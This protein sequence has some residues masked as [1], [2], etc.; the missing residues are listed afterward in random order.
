MSRRR[1]IPAQAPLLAA[2]LLLFASPLCGAYRVEEG[3]TFE[4]IAQ[5]EFGSP[6][7]AHLI[8]LH[9]GLPPD[10]LPPEGTKLHFPKAKVIHLMIPQRY[11]TLAFRL[12]GDEALA[13]LLAAV[14]GEASTDP[15]QF[16]EG[17]VV[18]AMVEYRR[19]DGESF[20]EVARRAYG[21]A[22]PSWP[23]ALANP[24]PRKVLLVPV[25]GFFRETLGDGERRLV[26][27]AERRLRDA[28]PPR[29][30]DP[31]GASGRLA[32]GRPGAGDGGTRPDADA[33]A[34]ADGLSQGPA[35]SAG[36]PRE[37]QAASGTPEPPAADRNGRTGPGSAGE[38]DPG[39]TGTGA[40]RGRDA[41]GSSAAAASGS[42]REA[43]G[44]RTPGTGAV[45]RAEGPGTRPPGSASTGTA[46]GSPGPADHVE[47]SE[48]PP[49]GGG[50]GAMNAD[51][52][53]SR[54]PG[55][56]AA[57][58]SGPAGTAPDRAAS[59]GS[60]PGS[61]DPADAGPGSIAPTPKASAPQPEP[62]VL[63][64]AV[65][66]SVLGQ[67]IPWAP[68][69]RVRQDH[70]HGEYH[71]A[72]VAAEQLL[73]SSTVPAELES[74]AWLLLGLSR[75]ARDDEDGAIDAF[76]H[77]RSLAPDLTLDPYYH[78]PKVLDT[79]ARATP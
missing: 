19:R 61:Q 22:S 60:S 23:I 66:R 1:S 53:A 52:P 31:S 72:Q 57:S 6:A 3:E 73:A 29:T 12:L 76:R 35:G 42:A 37:R 17:V 70:R 26:R 24:N 33:A 30:G 43:P 79:F 69:E 63:E 62:K 28:S 50:S 13:P 10:R 2:L 75:L 40:S 77:A 68:L 44:R 67:V 64:S 36:A 11:E 27:D 49:P 51:I 4:A 39:Q 34:A 38:P 54:S 14:N 16:R 20:E 59:H 8:A 55:T 48:D 46:A 21:A 18:P 5:A 71:R 78:P 58:P 56:A 32:D 74:T 7:L 15:V 41:A 47:S 65:V 9:N 45:T 25:I